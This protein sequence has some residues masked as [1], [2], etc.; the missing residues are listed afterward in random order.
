MSKNKKKTEDKVKINGIP[1]PPMRQLIVQTDGRII[2][3][4]KQEV[5]TLEL[6][7]ICQSLLS[8]LNNQK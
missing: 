1:Q 7:A 6:A 5:T 8:N 3:I 4:V 2:K